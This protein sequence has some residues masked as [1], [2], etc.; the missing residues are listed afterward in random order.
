MSDTENT[1]AEKK[2]RVG[3]I[4]KEGIGIGMQN[5]GP[6]LVN[7]ILW[8]PSLIIP[9]IN[10]GTTIGMAIGIVAKA[11]KGEPIS[12]TE[13]F[14]PQYRK[15]MGEYFLASGLVGIGVA[16]GTALFIIPGI[17]ISLAW[18]LALLL[19]V[20]KE[21]NP[22]EAITLSNK[23]TYGYKGTIFLAQFIVCIVACIALCIFYLLPSAVAA[24][25]SIAL[26]IVILFV[27]IGVQAYIY[28]TL[29]EN[30]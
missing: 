20:D 27:M 7:T 15:Y 3:S 5:F 29:C 8:I 23:L 10:I 16:A 30:V 21:K 18:S 17:V 9:Y 4:L 24:I 6:I 11:G 12:M 14:N 19:T 25:L 26:I 28:K 1:V 2:L 22:T 13:I